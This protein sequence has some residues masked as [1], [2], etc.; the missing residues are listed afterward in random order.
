MCEDKCLRFGVE[1]QIQH[2]DKGDKGAC[3]EDQ[4]QRENIAKYAVNNRGQGHAAYA[5]GLNEAQNCTA[6][7]LR[8]SQ[9]K[10]GI[11]NCVAGAVE[12]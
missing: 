6:V 4:I 1:A 7:F 3:G 11:E 9:H 5:A 10:S 12:K 8:Q 2:G